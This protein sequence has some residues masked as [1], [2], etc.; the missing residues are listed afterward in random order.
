MKRRFFLAALTLLAIAFAAEF[1][2]AGRAP[3]EASGPS[4][5][6][7]SEKGKFRIL[8]RG[9]VAAKEEFEIAPNG[10]DW[11][12]HG[13]TEVAGPQGTTR[14]SATLKLAADGTPLHYE[15]NTQSAK[16]ASATVEFQGATAT[17]E[18]HLEGSRPFTQQFTFNS[19]RVVV[20]D[21]NLY[22]H[23]ALLARMYDWQKKGPQTFS[24]LI[25]QEMTPGSVTVEALGPQSVGGAKLEE[26]RVHS[27]D[28][29]INLYLDAG[30]L[31]RIIA[32][33][34]NAEAI[35]E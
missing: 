19:P 14:V 1:S 21:N 27:E 5:V 13:T 17:I 18:L 31:V 8:V 6:F 28:L 2:P 11:V 22:H 10:N 26:L 15:W 7:T 23:Y 25:P 16:K 3:S 29:E 4:P 9:E 12:A 32:P 20:L 34:S 24:V 33:S 35:R 30:R